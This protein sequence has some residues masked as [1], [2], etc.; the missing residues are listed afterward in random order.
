M[1]G[2]LELHSTGVSLHPADGTLNRFESIELY[3]DTL[4]NR[5]PFYKFD[6]AAFGGSVEH[7]DL[8]AV[9]A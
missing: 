6:F 9:R 8:K 4:P 2:P 3:P 1:Q 7:P 5:R